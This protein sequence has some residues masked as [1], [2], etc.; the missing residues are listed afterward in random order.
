MRSSARA[1]IPRSRSL[2]AQMVLVVVLT[3]VVPV[4]LLAAVVVFLPRHFLVG[5]A[6]A[7]AL[8]V[9]VRVVA[10]ARRKAP[11]GRVL[12]ERDD[13]DLFAILDRLCVLAD[14]PRPDVV[15]SRQRQPNSWVIHLP[16][17]RPRL[18][19]TTALRDLLTIDELQAVLGHELAH[20]ANRDALVMSVVGM[21]GSVMLRASGG[22]VDGLLVVVI[23]ALSRIGTAMLS[24]HRELAADTGSAAITGRPSALASALLKVSGSLEQ[25][26]KRDLR[27]AVA[28]NAFNLVAVNAR[29]R[30]WQDVP[31][32]A[33]VAATHP[34]LTR[35]VDALSALE[36]RHHVRRRVS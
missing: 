36:H 8:G 35:R 15:L 10:H 26:P 23:G 33:R 1:Q 4:V 34:A 13:P 30:W 16:H 21:P 29:H 12:A 5:L 9:I 22:G 24:R 18:Y 28:L 3:A 7:L 6:I 32:L 31:L 27:D 11:D 2:T 25:V 19:L 14:L 20:I 17:H